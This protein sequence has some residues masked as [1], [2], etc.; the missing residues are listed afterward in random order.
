[1]RGIE[2]RRGLTRVDEKMGDERNGKEKGVMRR[3]VGKVI[4]REKIR[5]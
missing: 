3:R 1:M 5:D 4:E 2:K